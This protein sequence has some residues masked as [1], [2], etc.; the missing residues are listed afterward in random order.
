LP[1]WSF[2]TWS[3]CGSTTRFKPFAEV[4]A[5]SAVTRRRLLFAK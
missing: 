3:E 4:V 1:V 5:F 2:F